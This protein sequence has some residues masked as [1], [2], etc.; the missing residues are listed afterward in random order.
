MPGVVSVSYS[1]EALLSDSLWGSNV[2]IIGQPDSVYTDMLAAGP[3]FLQ[4]MK[5]PL[6]EG[7]SFTPADFARRSRQMRQEKGYPP[8]QSAHDNCSSRPCAY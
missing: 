7:R 4:T 1:S 6:L 8:Q 5:I 2:A 3:N